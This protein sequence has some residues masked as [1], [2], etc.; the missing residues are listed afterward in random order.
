MQVRG[1]A[2]RALVVLGLILV[3]G[4]GAGYGDVA[5]QAKAPST[6]ASTIEGSDQRLAGALLVE[7]ILPTAEN[8]LR[9]AQEYRRLRILD[10][11]H[12]RLERALRQQPRLSAAH[13]EMARVWRDWGFPDMALGFAYRAVYFD[14]ATPS[15]RNTLGTVLDALGLVEEA[16]QAYAAAVDRDPEAGWA[17][18]NLC[19]LE[20]RMGRFAEARRH[21]EAAI[22]ATPALVAAHNNLGLTFAAAGRLDQA[23]DAFLAMGDSAAA[24][25]NVAIVHLAN[26]EYLAAALE[27]ELAIK[28]R[29]AFTAAKTRAH[30]ARM[31]VLTNR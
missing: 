20:F 5:A 27:L 10:S 6:A 19:S 11:A 21:C 30:E 1:R 8:Q 26:K 18:N 3:N 17:L 16:R 23:R 7:K 24:H 29:P 25:Y 13:E 9:V 28:E 31:H 14:P 12:E 4:V 22:R 2:G 15:A